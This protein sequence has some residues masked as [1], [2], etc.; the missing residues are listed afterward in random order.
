M[1][2]P[3]AAALHFLVVVFRS[4]SQNPA[5]RRCWCTASMSAKRFWRPSANSSPPGAGDEAWKA[6]ISTICELLFLFHKQSG[7][8]R[9]AQAAGRLPEPCCWVHVVTGE[10]RRASGC[11]CWLVCSSSRH[12]HITEH[13]QSMGHLWTTCNFARS[14]RRHGYLCDGRAVGLHAARPRIGCARGK[15]FA[16]MW[17]AVFAQSANDSFPS[18]SLPERNTG[19]GFKRCAASATGSA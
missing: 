14:G 12:C 19:R 18:L 4:A 11:F 16:G 9:G 7:E 8:R 13:R 1:G 2:K 5:C 17:R 6:T 3:A 15:T 10:R